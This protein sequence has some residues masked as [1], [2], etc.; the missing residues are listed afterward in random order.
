MPP[1]LQALHL[2]ATA[3]MTG[4]GVYAQRVHYPMLADTGEPDFS[5]RHREYTRRMG[6]VAAP[7]MLLEAGLQLVWLMRAPSLTSSLGTALLVGVWFFTFALIVPLHTRLSQGFDPKA[8]RLL[9]RHNGFRTLFWAARAL[10]L[11][12]GISY[13]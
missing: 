9:V 1:L 6:P 11:V 10:L 12:G 8:K 13:S 2:L 5:T 3:Y 7:M 4:V